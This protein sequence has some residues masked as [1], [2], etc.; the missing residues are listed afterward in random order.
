MQSADVSKMN[1]QQLRL[2]N[3]AV[4]AFVLANS[5]EMVTPL[6]TGTVTPSQQSVLNLQL[7]QVG[8]VKGF[9]VEVSIPVTNS[10]A[11][12]AS[13]TDFGVANV[14]SNISFFD[15][16]GYQRI[17]TTGW[18]LNFLNSAKE[19]RPFGAADLA[20]SMDS[21]INYG[22]TGSI[23]TAPASIAAA[24]NGTIKMMYWV[25]LAYS[26]ADLRGSVFM[27]VVN[28]TAY[29]QLTLNPSMSLTAGDTS[30]VPYSGGTSNVAASS[31]TFTVYQVYLDQLPRW[32]SGPEAG[33]PMLPPLDTATQY[34]LM[35]T[36][37]TG[38]T[39]GQDFAVPF[40]N[41]Q[42]FLSATIIYDQNGTRNAGSDINYFSLTTANTLNMFK[43]DPFAQ[44][45]KQRMRIHTDFPKGVYMFDFRDAP[46][47]TNQTGN[48]QLN[49]NPSSAAASTT[50]YVGF[51]SFALTN[52]VLGAASL[53]SS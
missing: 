16:D 46:I 27:G 1:P 23:I 32:T 33:K 29:L 19:G 10:G 34:R 47:S 13:I 51:E 26:K 20:T 8:L 6:Y 45:L 53:P 3:D 49:I 40:T 15:L 9:L 24:G 42:D 30:F 22:N 41:F 25:P 38:V 31:A 4:R 37:L 50:A 12:T 52:N 5:L 14:L 43:L 17:N 39:A 36:S 48:M 21:P 2:Y 35:Q 7:R 44:M 18:H 11:G 28:A